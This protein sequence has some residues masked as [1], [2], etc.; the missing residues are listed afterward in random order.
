MIIYKFCC[1][2]FISHLLTKMVF[3]NQSI[4]RVF[5]LY[6]E[7]VVLKSTES[8]SLSRVSVRFGPL[9]GY[10]TLFISLMCMANT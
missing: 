3:F 9:V 8:G 10:F 4:P 5:P 7:S 6:K 1:D 2:Y